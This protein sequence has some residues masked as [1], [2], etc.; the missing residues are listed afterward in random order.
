[1]PDLVAHYCHAQVEENQTIRCG[2]HHLHEVAEM[3]GKDGFFTQWN[4]KV[5]GN[6]NKGGSGRCQMLG[7]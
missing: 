4:L 3:S 5:V 6:E 1:M 2:A 7:F